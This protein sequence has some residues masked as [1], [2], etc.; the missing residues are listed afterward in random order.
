M[1]DP[2]LAG[3]LFGKHGAVP[4]ATADAVV[5]DTAAFACRCATSAAPF[6]LP[7][8]T[9]AFC[10]AAASPAPPNASNGSDL[11]TVEPAPP[12]AS[13]PT[14]AGVVSLVVTDPAVPGVFVVVVW[15]VVPVAAPVVASV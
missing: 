3:G 11:L 15:T 6:P 9:D 2:L 13:N 14:S 12:N 10:A 1:P 8:A 5:L 7:L 4:V